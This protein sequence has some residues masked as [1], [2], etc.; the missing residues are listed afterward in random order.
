MADVS[1]NQLE[2]SRLVI[3]LVTGDEPVGES[4]DVVL[5]CPR[6]AIGL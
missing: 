2:L 5:R 6:S 4:V 3:N 1:L